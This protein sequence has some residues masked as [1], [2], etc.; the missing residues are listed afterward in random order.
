M[1]RRT[2]FSTVAAGALSVAIAP[3]ASAA[4]EWCE[5]DPAVRLAT[6]DGNLV[7][8][9]TNYGRLSGVASADRAIRRAVASA[10]VGASLAQDGLVTVSVFIPPVNEGA[11]FEVKSV[12][13]TKP[14]ARGAVLGSEA[15]GTVGAVAGLLTITFPL[16][17]LPIT[18]S[19]KGR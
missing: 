7:V 15:T 3:T 4:A 1:N 16:S 11:T 5:H 19:T 12:V 10:S 18:K 9:V 17:E 13:S 14:H 2:V 6:P 8:H